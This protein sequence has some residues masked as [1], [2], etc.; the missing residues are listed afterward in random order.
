MADIG[1]GKDYGTFV[2]DIKGDPIEHV[3]K[4]VESCSKTAN[5]AV[6]DDKIKII[7]DSN[8][9]DGTYDSFI[10]A[11]GANGYKNIAIDDSIDIPITEDKSITP[12]G[13]IENIKTVVGFAIGPEKFEAIMAALKISGFNRI[14][15]EKTY[16]VDL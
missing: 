10:V 6:D 16:I 15:I 13:D 5:D 8:V 3:A 14:K 12:A 1:T 2:D 9:G 7:I 11:L 4:I